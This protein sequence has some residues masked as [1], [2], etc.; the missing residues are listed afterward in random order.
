MKIALLLSY[1]FL[2]VE[3]FSQQNDTSLNFYKVAI[4]DSTNLKFVTPYG[5]SV[6]YNL[7][8]PFGPTVY[9]TI[10]SPVWYT[11][12]T[13]SI[14]EVTAKL[15]SSGHYFCNN[16]DSVYSIAY[17]VPNTIPN[18]SSKRSIF[19]HNIWLGGISESGQLHMTAETYRQVGESFWHG[20]IANN[21]EDAYDQKYN[22]VW[23]IDKDTID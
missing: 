18:A 15:F 21:Y 7:N 2:S 5:D 14:N 11:S 6:F 20:P 12:A 19:S 23:K 17:T 3:T 10:Y 4:V 13:L 9:D 22:K 1:I 16:Q 8:H